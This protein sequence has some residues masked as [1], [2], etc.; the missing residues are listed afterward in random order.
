MLILKDICKTYKSKKGTDCQ[1][2]KNIN[3]TF[4][5]RGLVFILGKSGSGKS[6][7][8]NV[9]G[10]LD[11]P[12]CGEIII[13]GKS[14]K[15]FT[16]KDYDS[17]RNTYL[18]FIF[19]EYN[20]MDDFT[21]WDNVALALKLQN[22]TVDKHVIQNIL[23][24]VGLQDFEKRK[25]NE[26][27]GGQKQR[28]AIARALVKDPEIIFGDEPTGNL[29]SNTSSQIFDLLRQLSSKKLVVIV[30][31]DRESAIKYADRIIEL[32]DGNV[33]SDLTR[34]EHVDNDFKITKTS[35]K[36]PKH[37][38]L[39]NKEI[40]DINEAIKNSDGKIKIK[41]K[42]DSVFLKT[43]KIV[44]TKNQGFKLI[45][46]K[47][48]NRYAS[49]I[50][51]SN[52]KTKK[53][54]LVVTI[55]LTV[56]A[57]S[58]FGL[59]QIF[60][61]YDIAKASSG[62][63][64]K[65]NINQ[66]ILK[67]GEYSRDYDS[68][69]R[70]NQVT[71]DTINLQT[72][73]RLKTLPGN[74]EFTEMYG[75]N[76]MISTSSSS[77]IMDM[78][79]SV[80]GRNLSTPYTNTITGNL[81]LTEQD[82]NKYFLIEGYNQ[83]QFE[84]GEFPKQNENK[85]AITDYLADC[86]ISKN[87]TKLS[88]DMQQ[89]QEFDDSLKNQEDALYQYLMFKGFDD[90]FGLHYDISGIILTNYDVTF[91]ELLEAYKNDPGLF[92]SHEDYNKFAMLVENYYSVVFS[93]DK[94]FIN[95]TIQNGTYS[96]IKRYKLRAA[97]K[98]YSKTAYTSI[99]YAFSLKELLNLEGVDEE[100]LVL[101]K[102]LSKDAIDLLNTIENSIILPVDVYDSLF[103]TQVS[104][105][106][107]NFVYYMDDS[108]KNAEFNTIAIG[109]YEILNMQDGPKKEQFL[110]VVGVVDFDAL[111]TLIPS[112]ESYKN[113][114][115]LI[116]SEDYLLS[117]KQENY[118]L[119]GLYTTL[120]SSQFYNE[121]LL[122]TA[123]SLNLYHVTEISD[124]LYMVSNI[125]KIFS[126]I[127]QWVALILGIFSVILLSNFVSLSVINKQKDIG[128]LRAIGAKGSD[129]S[130]IFLIESTIMG[131]IIVAFSWIFIFLGTYLVNTILINSFKSFLQSTIIQNIT[132]LSAGILP[133][134]AVLL[135]CILI[136]FLATIIP[137]IKISRM[138]PVD[139]I[140]KVN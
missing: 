98:E 101:N 47:F 42:D 6:T 84:Y 52:F 64:E 12:D 121:N 74:F 97:L 51:V 59:S 50:A 65:N 129:V 107:D 131:A 87:F 120:S 15:D 26:L 82:L 11:A 136:V 4:P 117:L 75:L 9:I 127:F 110:K 99:G 105:N 125:F 49:Q 13:K 27:S 67:Q 20:V 118:A 81:I 77:N 44:N 114:V 19:Q 7:L 37:R 23:N 108:N 10:G 66:I 78:I 16:A 112:A 57:L 128:I 48:P 55:F 135:V 72:V 91:G 40:H 113:V 70:G 22:K 119:K 41:Q 116:A 29:D 36:I 28:V 92:T 63:F 124:T 14:S 83:V 138:K 31:H 132:L 32:A 79:M 103:K 25:P 104:E 53:F 1:A 39:T 95:N 139:A 90:A 62:S 69:L 58:L 106:I 2:L 5:D 54:R 126:L 130:K 133:L 94:T 24:Q 33:I 80:M 21:V 109:N 123:N 43:T 88:K 73:N 122:R 8:L 137:T 115:T 45:K 68:L 61:S 34:N 134:G 102:V 111:V 85:V 89:D 140:K 71:F 3:I 60:A 17:Y 30:S 46:S 18:G 93:P 86:I 38:S 100:Q 76:S 35:V 56:I 96:Q